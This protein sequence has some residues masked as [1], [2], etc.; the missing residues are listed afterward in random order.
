MHLPPAARLRA[1]GS[2]RRRAPGARRPAGGRAGPPSGHSQSR[3]ADEHD[4][5]GRQLVARGGEGVHERGLRLAGL[6][7]PDRYE[8]EVARCHAEPGAEP[9]TCGGVFDG[10]AI[11]R[12]DRDA[13]GNS[14]AG[15]GRPGHR[16]E[17]ITRRS[18][19]EQQPVGHAQQCREALTGAA[20]AEGPHLFGWDV[21]VDCPDHRDP[22][23]DQRARLPRRARCSRRRRRRGPPPRS[24]PARG[25]RSRPAV[26]RPR[27]TRA[28]ARPRPPTPPRRGPS[29]PLTTQHRSPRSCRCRT[30]SCNQSC[31]PPSSRLWVNTPMR[32]QLRPSSVG[33]LARTGWRWDGVEAC[34]GARRRVRRPESRSRRTRAQPP[35]RV[36]ALA[37]TTTV[38]P[39][40]AGS[41][42]R[43]CSKPLRAVRWADAGSSWL[44]SRR[45]RAAFRRPRSRR[46]R[47]R[48]EAA[49]SR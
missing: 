30:I 8:D 48:R 5:Y 19:H 28:L 22:E 3:V 36:T 20:V 29:L 34:R 39:A 42:C 4:V 43:V 16:A 32:R 26:R 41:S 24:P 49:W 31:A 7:R 13:V 2:R 46:R 18:T 40:P 11:E 33:L 47:A 21:L 44:K 6:D 37:V 27:R 15:A 17:E 9:I 38:F 12:C 1:P 35:S 45:V 25:Q 10:V 14:D 23:L